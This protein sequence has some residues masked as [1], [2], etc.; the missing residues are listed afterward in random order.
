VAEL[1]LAELAGYAS[2]LDEVAS[3]AESDF[4]FSMNIR[5]KFGL[6][7]RSDLD[8]SAPPEVRAIVWAVMYVIDFGGKNARLIPRENLGG[9]SI[10]PQTKDVPEDIRAIWRHLLTLVTSAT[11]KA[12]LGHV[13]FQCGGSAG[14]QAATTAIDSYIESASAGTRTSDRINDLQ[15]ASRLAR[16]MRDDEKVQRSLQML[17][18]ISEATLDNEPEKAGLVLRPLAHVVGEPRCPNRVDE[19]LER[20]A[21]DLPDADDRDDA[22]KLMQ[23]RCG[24]DEERRSALWER[25]V[26]VYLEAAEPQES[27]VMQTHL[28]QDAL[29]TAEASGNKALYQK[30][31]AALQNTRDHHAEMI[32]IESSVA[33]YE[34]EFI[35]LRDSLIRGDSWKQALVTFSMAGPLSG[36]YEANL[37]NTK[38]RHSLGGLSSLFPTVL[39]GPDGLPIYKPESEEDRIDFELTRFEAQ[40][41][42]GFVRPLISAI[43]AIPERFGLPT[44]AELVE[45]LNT[46]PGMSPAVAH[47]VVYALQRFWVG[48]SQGAIYTLTP[49]IETLV[50]DLILRANHGMY[51]LQQTPR[52]PGQ[53][54]GLGAMLDLLPDYYDVSEGWLHSLKTILIHPG[55][56]NFRNSLSHGVVIYGD[57]GTAAIILHTALWLASRSPVPEEPQTPEDSTNG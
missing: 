50:R 24:N 17:L 18:D 3:A 10:P 36:D 30:A 52:Q 14:P 41:I 46:W 4:E 13:V 54:P 5:E 43:D 26:D 42:N 32:R 53:Y 55:G 56:F 38:E 48:D 37:K 22:L 27:A 19:L 16:T 29:R 49:V 31:A 44:T 12:R 6:G 15:S 28:R 11:A 23:S 9:E 33:L 57:P 47:V 25:R 1:S 39:I 7:L 40:I 20:A 8:E 21:A 34:E 35:Q 51:R 45:F 2:V